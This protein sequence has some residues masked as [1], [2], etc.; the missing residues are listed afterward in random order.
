M[1]MYRIA[2]ATVSK[3]IEGTRTDADAEFERIL[4]VDRERAIVGSVLLYEIPE[5]NVASEEKLL[6]EEPLVPTAWTNGYTNE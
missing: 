2:G 3:V 6:R 1:T 5:P 4:V